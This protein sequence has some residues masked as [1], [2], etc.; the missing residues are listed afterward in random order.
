MRARLALLA[1]AALLGAELLDRAFWAARGWRERPGGFEV[2]AVGESTAAGEPYGE[3][4]APATLVARSL[5]ED[6][7]VLMLARTGESIYPQSV[8]LERA[9][10]GRGRRP[11]LVLVYSGHNDSGEPEADPGGLERLRRALAGRSA[12][13]RDAAFLL[14]RRFPGL[15]R[16]TL[17][18]WEHHL[19]RVIETSRA[20]GLTPVLAVPVSN[21][22]EIAPGLSVD[23]AG[24]ELDLWCRGVYR[25]A[26][27]ARALGRREEARRL[28][29]EAVDAGWAGNFGR[30]TSLH[31][32]RVRALAAEYRV[33][34]ADARAAFE[35]RSPDGLLGGALFIDGHH[36]SAEGYRVLAQTYAA[37]AG[38]AL[39]R[40]FSPVPPA[41]ETAEALVAGGRWLFTVSARQADP[42]ERL[43][44]AKDRFRRALAL[45]A[46]SYPA[47]VGLKLSE[48]AER[49][50]LLRSQE[51]LDWLGRNAL[52][53]GRTARVSCPDL[54]ELFARYDPPAKVEAL[55][56][57]CRPR[58]P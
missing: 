49:S 25:S 30:A 5:G 7:R 31:E 19:R 21:Q 4:L 36:P 26:L 34:L 11:G 57:D 12:L 1:G 3:S 38:E 54:A 50:E 52:F 23:A 39:G 46:G 28:F 35:A 37:A 58:S 22:T 41:E 47:W 20:R 8:A 10:T 14:E 17:E 9:L 53:Y 56:R 48:L 27:R 13:L 33:P 55:R 45:D 6:A 2:Y 16:R 15:R 24:S 32:A 44:L 40:P 42:R 43:A 29:Q 51:G 18:S